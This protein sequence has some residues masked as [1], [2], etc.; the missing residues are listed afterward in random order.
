MTKFKIFSDITKETE[1]LNQMAAEGQA[2]TNYVAGFYTFEDC[3]AGKYVFKVDLADSF[4]STTPD[5]RD[6]RRDT[7]TTILQAWSSKV[8]LRKEAS[9]AP[10]ADYPKIDGLLEYFIKLRDIFK[11]ASLLE[12]ICVVLELYAAMTDFTGAFLLT[13]G[14]GIILLVCMKMVVSANKTVLALREKKGERPKEYETKM[15]RVS[16]SLF[17]AIVCCCIPFVLQFFGCNEGLIGAL[18]LLSF[19]LLAV[20]IIKTRHIWGR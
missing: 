16:P 5:Y 12:M 4:F 20:G 19:V 13:L 6:Y 18:Q 11:L 10:I 17:I 2:F 14:I 8:Y 7:D 3:P 15:D 1:W 9:K